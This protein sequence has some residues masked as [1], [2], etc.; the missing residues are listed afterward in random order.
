MVG[1]YESSHMRLAIFGGAG[2][3]SVGNNS[4]DLNDM[5]RYDPKTGQW[6]WVKGSNLRGAAGVYRTLG[7][8]SPLNQPGA[9][10]SGTAWI[11]YPEHVWL[12]GGAGY[13]SAGSYDYYG[14]N[15]IFEYIP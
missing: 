1:W 8:P 10:N 12:F 14:L 7:T 11:D 13:D 9:R 2:Y 5:W 3:D 6:T 15:D 4:T